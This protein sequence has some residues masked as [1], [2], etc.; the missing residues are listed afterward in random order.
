MGE[1]EPQ[2]ERIDR[3]ELF[4]LYHPETEDVFSGYGLTAE[5]MRKDRLVGLLLVDRPIVVDTKWLESLEK[6]YGEC[7]LIPMT[8][9]GERGLICQMEVVDDSLHHLRQLPSNKSKAIQRALKP[10][11]DEPPAPR[12]RLHWDEETRFWNSE[13]AGVN[14]LPTEIREVFEKTGYG[15]LAAETNVGIVHVC[16]ASDED[17]DSFSNKPVVIRWQLIKMPTAPLIRLELVILDRPEDP[18]RFES[19]LNIG[20]EDQANILA[21]LAN[22]D[23][24]HLAFYG[25]DLTYR[26]TKS[27]SHTEQQWQQLDELVE[28]ATRYSEGIPSNQRDF[29]RAKREFFMS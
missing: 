23:M 26:Y 11:L 24:L 28:Q 2:K 8:D 14:E 4:Y 16:H 17:I 10:L 20:E 15:S 18:F 22:Q 25:S 29:D 6:T 13:F 12:L 5:P 9:K 1:Q 19:F 27:I 7:R 21:G 3:G